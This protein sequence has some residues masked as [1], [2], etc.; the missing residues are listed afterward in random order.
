MSQSIFIKIIKNFMIKNFMNIKKKKKIKLSIDTK[1]DL[2]LILKK[3]KKKFIN[4]S[5]K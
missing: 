4:F 2:K 1:N 5:L 3:L